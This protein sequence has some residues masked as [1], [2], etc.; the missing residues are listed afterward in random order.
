MPSGY[1]CYPMCLLG[2]QYLRVSKPG[3]DFLPDGWSWLFQCSQLEYSEIL[4]LL[5]LLALDQLAVCR[6]EFAPK[7]D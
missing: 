6:K 2:R 1:I 5:S 4:G 7:S 3:T